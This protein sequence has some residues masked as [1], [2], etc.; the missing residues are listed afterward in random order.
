MIPRL[1]I[2]PV[3]SIESIQAIAHRA[4]EAC[5]AASLQFGDPVHELADESGRERLGRR[6]SNRALRGLILLQVWSACARMTA[7][8]IG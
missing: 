7:G 2:P 3:E 8:L 6:K 5:A 1:M 4:A